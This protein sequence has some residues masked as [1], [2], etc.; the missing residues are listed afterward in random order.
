MTRICSPP[1]SLIEA[2]AGSVHQHVALIEQQ[3]HARTAHAFELRGD[4]VVEAL[5][6]RFGVGHRSIAAQPWDGLSTSDAR[7]ATALG[8]REAMRCDA[9]RAT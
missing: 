4:E 1:R 3:L 9:A 8:Q 6:A 5:A 7:L 2:L